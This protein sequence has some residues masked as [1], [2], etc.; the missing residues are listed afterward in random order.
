MGHNTPVKCLL[1]WVVLPMTAAA[2]QYRP[3]DKQNRSEKHKY[4]VLGTENN[5]NIVK[6]DSV[7][8]FF[9]NLVYNRVLLLEV[10]YKQD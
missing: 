1:F 5:Q 8:F 4:Q 7:L 2:C 10:A 9:V 3:N 6:L